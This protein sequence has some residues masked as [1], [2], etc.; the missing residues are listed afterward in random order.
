M[1]KQLWFEGYSTRKASW[2]ILGRTV[3]LLKFI[4]NTRTLGCLEKFPRAS[5]RGH[6]DS[7]VKSHLNLALCNLEITQK[8]V[9]DQ[10]KQ[11]ERLA[12]T[13]D[14]QSQQLNDQSQQI[15]CLTST[16]QGLVQQME[17]LKNKTTNEA[18]GGANKKGATNVKVKEG[19][20]GWR[21]HASR[22]RDRDR[23]GWRRGGDDAG[24]D[25]ERVPPRPSLL[26]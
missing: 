20:T 16:V 4:V 8:Q 10:S 6:L 2:F 23:N 11:I 14:D 18:M 17:R 22:S 7:H 24:R 21:N 25:Q 5:T 15:A 19:V 1:Y 9:R 12:S 3:S 26:R 13:C